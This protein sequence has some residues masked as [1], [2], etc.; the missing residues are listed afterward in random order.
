MQNWLLQNDFMN[1]CCEISLVE[2][3]DFNARGRQIP[4]LEPYTTGVPRHSET[5]RPP[6]TM[7]RVLGVMMHKMPRALGG[8]LLYGST[9]EF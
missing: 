8:V 1:P 2:A 7:P 9:V 3:L 5:A 4:Q 6:R